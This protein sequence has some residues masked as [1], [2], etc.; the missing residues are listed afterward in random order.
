MDEIKIARELNLKMIKGEE[1]KKIK[2]DSLEFVRFKSSINELTKKKILSK[3]H[4]V[5]MSY[6]SWLMEPPHYD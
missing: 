4:K 2:K 6:N 3:A 1:V 5:V